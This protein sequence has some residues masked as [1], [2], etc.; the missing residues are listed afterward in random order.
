MTRQRPHRL[1]AGIGAARPAGRRK[2]PPCTGGTMVNPARHPLASPTRLDS[3]MSEA[4]TR[5]LR[6]RLREYH[7][8]DEAKVVDEL[9]ALARCSHSEQQ[10][11]RERAVPLVQTV[12]DSR[13]KT[14][15][16]DAFLA[17][18]DLSSREGVVLM[19]LAEAL[20]RIPDAA[21]VDRLIRD[22]I[23]NTEWEKRLGASHSTFVNAGTWALMLTG[24][25]VN[26]D[27]QD[28]NLGGTLKRMVA[29]AGEPV[30]RQ[31]VITAMRILGRQFVMG[32]NIDE[33]IERARSAERNGYRHSY[34]ML[35]EAARTVPPTPCATSSPTATRSPPSATPPP[36]G[37]RFE[38]PSVSIKLSALHPRYEVA[39]EQR[40]RRELWPA[41]KEL[42][43]QARA[44]N[45]GFTIDAEE[46]DRL[47][48]SL[49]LI[50]ALALI[51]ELAG[52]D[53]LGLAVQAYQKRALATA[54][55]ARRPRAPRQPA[56]DGAPGQGRLL[57]RRDQAGAGARP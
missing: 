12:R 35:G 2:G 23:G 29:R 43:L 21:T 31:A 15:G 36:A 7:R 34:D 14:G 44:R 4:H 55:L 38:A 3:S 8:I 50:E 25:I 11:I 28:R 18:Y 48:I 40:V 52:W 16:I 5:I 49:D 56:A 45:I 53:G 9:V 19:C 46:M 37:R 20:L 30:I 54:R 1:P 32:R 42:A 13:L 57:G 22:K 24:R 27:N 6:R 47:E 17:T 10:G 39:N 51:S 26:L 41:V 33:A